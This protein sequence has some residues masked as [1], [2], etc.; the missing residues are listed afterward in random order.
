MLY[1]LFLFFFLTN[2]I[3]SFENRIYYGEKVK[4][5]EMVNFMVAITNYKRVIC[6][7]ALFNTRTVITAAHCLQDYRSGMIPADEY[8]VVGGA[9]NY[10]ILGEEKKVENITI[11]ENYG[12]P[13]SLSNDVALMIIE[14]PFSGDVLVGRVTLAPKKFPWPSGDRGIVFG[15]GRTETRRSSSYLRFVNITLI[16]K[17]ECV[18][19]VGNYISKMDD[20]MECAG[21]EDGMQDS[22][23]G[24][25]GG[26]LLHIKTGLMIGIV[27]FGMRCGLGGV[28]TKVGPFGEWILEHSKE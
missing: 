28:Y 7:G 26:P 21:S 14:A 10:V 24:D 15:W 11:H 17:E 3:Y 5:F 25:S 13:W 9:L 27:S 12:I 22:C 1:F 16:P 6:G 2:V 19:I 20:N 18:N 23:S 8:E 4:N